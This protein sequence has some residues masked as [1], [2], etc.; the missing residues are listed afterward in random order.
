MSFVATD[1]HQFTYKNIDEELLWVS[2]MPCF[3]D[4]QREIPLARYGAS[5]V[6]RMKTIYRNGLG[7]RYGRNMQAIAGI[8][9]NYSLPGLTF[10]LH[11]SFPCLT[12]Y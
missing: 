10:D 8:H 11:Y 12:F 7:L 5:N 2:S 9:F 1:I 6:G 4:E 3:L